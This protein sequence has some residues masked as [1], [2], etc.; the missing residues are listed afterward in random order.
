MSMAKGY[1]K[2]RHLVWTFLSILA[3]ISQVFLSILIVVVLIA[4][5]GF[6]V[7][8][9][10]GSSIADFR[11]DLPEYQQRLLLLSD[12]CYLHIYTIFDPC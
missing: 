3:S 9:I 1:S 7:G 4:I 8:V 11:E 12:T 6:G 5:L 2:L 10:V